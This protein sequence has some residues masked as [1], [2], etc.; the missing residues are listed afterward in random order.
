MAGKRVVRF[1]QQGGGGWR[2]PGRG[3]RPPHGGAKSV[4][5]GGHGTVKVEVPRFTLPGYLAR[6]LKEIAQCPPGH[7]F[8]LYFQ[9]AAYKAEVHWQSK[10]EKKEKSKAL[11]SRIT[12]QEW[13][14]IYNDYPPE[15]VWLP[16]KDAKK[17]ALKSV[18]A[19]PEVSEK[20][21]AA[22]RARQR[23]LAAAS[24]GKVFRFHT[25]L[26]APLAIGLGNP[27]PVENGF[28]FLQ[29]YGIAYI[30]GSSIKGAVRRT[31]E[32]LALAPEDN[33]W[34]IPLVWVLFG[35]D[36]TSS[37]LVRSD[38][39]LQ[40]DERNPR[41]AFAEY[42]RTRADT[43][44]LLSW[45]LKQ[46]GIRSPLPREQSGLA[47]D[48]ARFCQHLQDPGEAGRQ[49]R[50]SIHWQ[51]LLRFWDVFP[52]ADSMAVDI[53]NPHHREYYKGDL[54]TPV[55]TEAPKPVFFLTLPP[56]AD[57]V[58]TC[59]LVHRGEDIPLPDNLQDLL[60]AVINETIEWTGFGAKTAIGYGVGEMVRVDKNAST[61]SDNEFVEIEK[62]SADAKE[63]WS[64]LPEDLAWLKKAQK[65]NKWEASDN[66]IFLADIESFFEK[67][68]APGSGALDFIAEW[69]EK[70][71][72]G[73][74]ANPDAVK[75]KKN[76]PKY[77]ERPKRIAKLVIAK[78]KI[79]KGK[80]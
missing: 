58:I 43:D 49:L 54:K 4:Q 64:H 3:G 8:L 46:K 29:P 65:L 52:E 56:G 7:R 36:A 28:S 70:K 21:L 40:E 5:R 33:G 10:Q 53:L 62:P 60:K 17:Y 66:S 73:I 76:K 47:G 19:I 6:R 72:P 24:L 63:E 23:A 14:K 41:S 79:Q 31:A 77:K 30:P 59:E 75:G 13:D 44:P 42:A 57:M 38:H 39:L 69:I 71:W 16:L 67:F 34:T 9:G 37:Y 35:F 15:E 26:N 22:I 74:F 51:G 48:P 18:S 20:M 11:N 55:E 1:D 68:N 12:R 61:V 78:R 50:S 2:G 80:Y 27:H 25:R 45:W 32:E